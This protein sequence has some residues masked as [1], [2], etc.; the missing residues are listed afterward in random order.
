MRLGG[1]CIAPWRCNALGMGVVSASHPAGATHW[2]ESP[3]EGMS[4]FSFEL[5]SYSGM[6]VLVPIYGVTKEREDVGLDY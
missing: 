1:K 2:G 4:S 6:S 5:Q 3:L